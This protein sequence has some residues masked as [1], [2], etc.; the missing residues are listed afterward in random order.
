MTIFRRFFKDKRRWILWWSVGTAGFVLL[1]IAFYP[2]FKEFSQF[3]EQ[4][5]DAPEGVRALMGGQGG[6][7]LISPEGFLHSQVFAQALPIL[8]LIF[9]IGLGSRAIAGAEGDGTLELLMANPVTRRRV[10]VERYMTL[11]AQ[12]IVLGLVATVVILAFAPLV[13]LDG[14]SIANILAACAGAVCFGIVHATIAFAA[15]AV[16][17]K[18]GMAIAT[19]ASVGFG[20][21]VLFGLVSGGVVEP[22]RFLSPWW[23]YVSRN[24]VALGLAPESIWAPLAVSAVLVAGSVVMFERRDLRGSD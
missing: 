17:G 16:T 5:K 24:T 19:S 13:Q 23:G 15:G 4:L 22:F 21:F 11:V 20:G 1:S 12:T 7:S 9:A 18:R 6:I 14:L 8:L 3:D 10:A 2:A